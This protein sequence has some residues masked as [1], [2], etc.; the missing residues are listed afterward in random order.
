ML[1]MKTKHICACY[2]LFII[3]AVRT[4]LEISWHKFTSIQADLEIVPKYLSIREIVVRIS[5]GNQVNRVVHCSTVTSVFRRRCVDAN[6]KNL[7]LQQKHY[8]PLKLLKV[9]RLNLQ[10]VF[11]IK[12]WFESLVILG[13]RRL[14]WEDNIKM[15]LQEVGSLGYGLDNIIE[16]F[17][18][19]FAISFHHQNLIWIFSDN[20]ETQA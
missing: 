13:R 11:I 18:I 1:H 9:F 8:L 2:F 3:V 6:V 10:L 19:E 17:L 16:R 4:Q 7:H 15:D 14:R 20:G 12:I 5:M